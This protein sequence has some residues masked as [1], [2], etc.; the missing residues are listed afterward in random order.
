MVRCLHCHRVIVKAD[1]WGAYWYHPEGQT[2]WCEPD[3][4]TRAVPPK[5]GETQKRPTLSGMSRF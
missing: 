3:R 4:V 1:A 2:V 5:A